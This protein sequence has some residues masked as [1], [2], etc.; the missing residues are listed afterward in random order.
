MSAADAANEA[1][2]KAKAKADNAA[3]DAQAAEDAYYTKIVSRG[4]TQAQLDAEANAIE[5]AKLIGGTTIKNPNGAGLYVVSPKKADEETPAQKAAR[6]AA[7][8]A[9]RAAA[10]AAARAA[11]EEA[12]AKA[13]RD[14]AAAEAALAGAK[15]ARE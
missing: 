8:A 9:A 1:R 2:L 13:A 5:T 7:E 10:E 12:A 14:K 11:A 3:A 6:A 15:T 4:M